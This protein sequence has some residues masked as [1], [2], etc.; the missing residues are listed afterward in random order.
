MVTYKQ[1]TPEIRNVFKRDESG[2]YKLFA[3]VNEYEF[4]DI[5]VQIK[6]E[7]DPN[8]AVQFEEVM[9]PIDTDG[10]LHWPKG[11]FDVS[12]RYLFELF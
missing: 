9:Y 12:E 1:I 11:L 10:R 4:F 5:R 7:R 6:N 8:F 2:E 3:T